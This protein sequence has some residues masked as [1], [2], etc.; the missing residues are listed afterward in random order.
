MKEE[1]ERIVT[2]SDS[3]FDLMYR[4]SLGTTGK[5]ILIYRRIANGT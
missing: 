3:G 4:G 1:A 2:R 5:E